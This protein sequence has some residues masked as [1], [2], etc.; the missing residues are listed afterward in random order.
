[1]ALL[2]AYNLGHWLVNMD[3]QIPKNKAESSYLQEETNFSRKC[4]EV[5]KWLPFVA[6]AGVEGWRGGPGMKKGFVKETPLQKSLCPV[7]EL[8]SFHTE[9]GLQGK[10]CH[11]AI[12]SHTPITYS[13]NLPR[14]LPHV[15]LNVCPLALGQP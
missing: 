9:A 4:W 5:V 7:S 8:Y 3:L 2:G 12:T 10:N 1:M 15:T 11:K 6:I 13:W 14:L